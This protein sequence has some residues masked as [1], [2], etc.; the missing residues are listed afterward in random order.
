[1][2][3]T[4]AALEETQRDTEEILQAPAPDPQELQR[5]QQANAAAEQAHAAQQ[6]ALARQ[7]ALIERLEA[8]RKKK[9]EMEKQAK[10]YQAP[11]A[12]KGAP[13]LRSL[14]L[15]DFAPSLPPFNKHFVSALA[16]PGCSVYDTFAFQLLSVPPST[17][18]HRPCRRSRRAAPARRGAAGGRGSI[19]GGVPQFE[20]RARRA[21]ARGRRVGGFGHYYFRA[22][23][24]KRVVSEPAAAGGALVG[25]HII[26]V[27]SI[28]HHRLATAQHWAAGAVG[29]Q[30]SSSGTHRQQQRSVAASCAYGG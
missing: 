6:Q 21:R 23:G 8:E 1:M 17:F 28:A 13:L 20:R 11:A 19:R 3:D 4:R 7:R 9:H 27:V 16:A 30:R 22:G 24:L 29:E 5:A 18:S 15:T 2:R 25:V 26:S 10:E 12:R 14:S